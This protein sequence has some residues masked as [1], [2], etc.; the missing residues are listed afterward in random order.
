MRAHDI[1]AFARLQ[2]L[3]ALG[4]RYETFAQKHPAEADAEIAELN[5]P[6]L[7]ENAW[8]LQWVPGVL[9]P[10]IARVSSIIVLD[11]C[12]LPGDPKHDP[13]LMD[14]LMPA[15]IIAACLVAHTYGV[16]PEIRAGQLSGRLDVFARL[17]HRVTVENPEELAA[18]ARSRGG[19]LPPAQSPIVA[20][21]PSLIRDRLIGL[22]HIVAGPANPVRLE[23]M[24][25][26]FLIA[27]VAAETFESLSFGGVVPDPSQPT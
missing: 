19:A 13:S 7:Q 23:I 24:T 10:K 17:L 22:A 2:E 14:V 5:T 15:A 4:R 26:I 25:V 20:C 27:A 21:L 9:R 3:I 6:G 16:V 12:H 11:L 8:D 18:I 1:E